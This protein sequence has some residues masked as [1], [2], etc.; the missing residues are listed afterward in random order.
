MLCVTHVLLSQSGHLVFLHPLLEGDV[1]EAAVNVESEVGGGSVVVHALHLVVY[2]CR[3]RCLGIKVSL[4][5]I[6]EGRKDVLLEQ[7]TS[8]TFCSRKFTL[9]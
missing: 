2:S 9:Y 7:D 6:N 4:L 5:I 1:G 8:K 3:A